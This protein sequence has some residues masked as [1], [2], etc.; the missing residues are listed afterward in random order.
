M[1]LTQTDCSY[2]D[3]DAEYYAEGTYV[4]IALSISLSA[5]VTAICYFTAKY[6]WNKSVLPLN[7]EAFLSKSDCVVYA[8]IAVQV[9]QNLALAPG[10]HVLDEGL[11]QFFAA[12]LI[13]LFEL[14]TLK[15]NNYFAKL[16]FFLCLTFV[17][18]VSSAW[19]LIRLRSKGKSLTTRSEKAGLLTSLFMT[20]VMTLPV[21]AA[22]VETY[23]CDVEEG[24][25]VYLRQDCSY[26]CWE[27]QQASV[28]SVSM[29]A[30]FVFSSLSALQMPLWQ[31]HAMDLHIKEQPSSSLIRFAVQ[32]FLLSF[33]RALESEQLI[34]YSIIYSIVI[35]IWAAFSFKHKPYNYIRASMWSFAGQIVCVWVGLLL[36]I[37]HAASPGLYLNVLLGIGWSLT[38]GFTLHRQFYHL[39]SML[40]FPNFQAIE[41]KKP[42]PDDSKDSAVE[43]EDLLSQRLHRL[44]LQI[45]VEVGE[46]LCP[47]NSRVHTVN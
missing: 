12:F 47:A 27:I 6:S 8:I 13:D 23:V 35:V 31:E 4:A 11:T 16:S 21:L 3:D 36:F 29:I 15:K 5:F 22:F 17:W 20:Q 38:V 24:G 18:V 32:F 26:V 43:G 33:K 25:S 45:A 2:D 14:K 10:L 19:L 34:A 41:I 46:V 42:Q 37:A 39:P 7:Y 28:F 44:N 1:R 30:V 40:A 9:L